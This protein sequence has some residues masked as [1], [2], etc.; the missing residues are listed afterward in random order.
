MEEETKNIEPTN[1]NINFT[2]TPKQISEKTSKYFS[3]NSIQ[4][5]NQT[6]A[7]PLIYS[8][9]PNT[10]FY[11]NHVFSFA[12]ELSN[13]TD[14]VITILNLYITFNSVLTFS[15]STQNNNTL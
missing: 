10:N 11:I 9:N 5:H 13:I 8:L 14:Y 2:I 12:F 15:K 1:L 4:S 6:K 3:Y 7:N